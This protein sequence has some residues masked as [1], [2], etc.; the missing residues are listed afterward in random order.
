MT[1]ARLTATVET[2]GRS[3]PRAWGYLRR[4]PSFWIGFIGV[5]LIVGSAIFAP[6]IAPH[7]PNLQF[8]GE[9]LTKSGD[10]LGPTAKF[11]LGTDKL[12]RDELSRLLYGA[13]TS[14]TVGIVAN[15]LAVFIGV[16]VGTTAAYFRGRP[17]KLRAFGRGPALSVPVEPILM[18]TTDAFLA[19][20]ALLVAIALVA[21]VGPS[22]GLV[23]VV[24]AAIL[25]TATCRIM[26]S[27]S[28][29]V[30]ASDFV[31]AAT[32]IGVSDR[33]MIVRHLL[34]HLVPLI[35]VYATLGIATTVLFEATLSFLGVG[36]PAPAASWGGM[37]IEH[38]GYYRTDP[39][40]VA[41]PGLAIMATILAFNLL[42]DALAD[43]LDPRKWR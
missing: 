19:F 23:I 9:G 10:P 14:L 5:V 25:W 12:G 26:Y 13:R 30:L 24:I 28:L 4:N 43:A 3:T 18:R 29:V 1:A 27:T 21:I 42:G 17:A 35:A 16:L 39:R 36:V 7:D 41:L 2:S 33:R 11:P 15:S 37:I 40:V 38:V 31:L 22:L 8:R 6:L 32:A 34:P 20:P